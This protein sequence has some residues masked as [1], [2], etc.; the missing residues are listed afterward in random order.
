KVHMKIDLEKYNEWEVLNK[1]IVNNEEDEV[2]VEKEMVVKMPTVK[3]VVIKEDGVNEKESLNAH[4]GIENLTE[5]VIDQSV[6]AGVIRPSAN[7]EYRD[8]TVFKHK[9]LVSHLKYS[10]LKEDS[11]LLVITKS[12]SWDKD[13]LLTVLQYH[14]M[15]NDNPK[16]I[17]RFNPLIFQRK[18][19]E[20]T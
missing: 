7:S 1:N 2:T 18:S 12:D 4:E 14:K 16:G 6:G 17:E 9:E 19:S 11:L 5:E 3:D 13:G 15:K 8:P 20:D 10:C